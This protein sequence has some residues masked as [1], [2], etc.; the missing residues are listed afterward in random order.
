M[1]ERLKR[2]HAF[3][4]CVLAHIAAA[5]LYIDEKWKKRRKIW[6]RDWLRE[7]E[8]LDAHNNILQELRLNDADGV[9]S[10]IRMDNDTCVFVL[11]GIKDKIIKQTTKFRKPISSGEQ[12][13][14]TSRFM[15]TGESYKSLS[16]QFRVANNT[17]VKCISDNL[18]IFFSS[19]KINAMNA[20]GKF[21]KK[22]FVK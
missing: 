9:R 20:L 3:G 16:F 8:R 4:M 14:L 6:V 2:R 21:V 1:G 10:H 17:H 5:N 18:K 11:E 19:N 15:A 13:S 12:L 7:R 22:S